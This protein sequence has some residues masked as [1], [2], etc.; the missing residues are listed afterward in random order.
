M[1]LRSIFHQRNYLLYFFAISASILLSFWIDWHETV[2]NSD[3][4]CYLLSA[5]TVGNSISSAMH[6]C[7]QAKWPFYSVLIYSLVQ[8]T[9][10]SYTFSAYVID[11]F[12]SLC[13]VVL[14]ILI[15]KELGGSKRVLWLSAFVILL[16]HNFNSVRV[17]II[18]DHGF[19]TFYL[20]SVLL[21][22]KYFTQPSAKKALGWYISLL[23]ATLFRIEGAIFLLV[24]PFLTWF[25]SRHP[26][27]KRAKHFAVLNVPTVLLVGAIFLW[28]CTHPQQTFNQLGRVAEVNQQLQHGLWLAIERYQQTKIALAQHVL[29]SDSVQDA[30]L[31]MAFVLFAWYVVNIINN[32]SWP[33]ALLVAYAWCK[34]SLPWSP[35]KL[36]I[37]GYLLVNILVTAG[38]FLEHLFFSKRYLIALS[39]ILML[40]VPFALDKL[41]QNS[42]TIRQRLLL[43]S[44]V[45]FIFV[46]SLG[47]I[48]DFGYS[49]S[50][51]HDAGDWLAENVPASAMLYANDYQLMYY[52]RHFGNKIFE[53]GR[54]YVQLNSIAHGQ[55]KQYD[56]L[57]LRLDKKPKNDVKVILDDIRILPV[58]IFQNKRG[59]QIAIYKVR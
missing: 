45:F 24:L 42:V 8:I 41:W 34:R 19:W 5:E 20:G 15:V 28:L 56:Y 37:A 58:Q 51:I 55:W 27:P 25:D 22:L 52:S 7:G 10:L 50:Y 49:K 48:F 59:D 40:Y 11:G 43:S 32:L 4:I 57:A 38:F 30:G 9:H 29:V 53:K 26:W 46:A 31:V 23:V 6:L 44:I 2:I 36:V 35:N 14:F 47:G 16:S 13:S 12:F 3:A 1:N 17:Y 21:L 54:F 33:Y 18:R 39:L